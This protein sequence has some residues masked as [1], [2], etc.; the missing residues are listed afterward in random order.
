VYTGL[1]DGR[2]VR[3]D[4]NNLYSDIETVLHTGNPSQA[5]PLPCGEI[6]PLSNSLDHILNI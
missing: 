3:F 4:L 6:N 2:I 5:L 1:A